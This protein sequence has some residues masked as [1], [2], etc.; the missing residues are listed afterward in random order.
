MNRGGEEG[1]YAWS[2]KGLLSVVKAVWMYCFHHLLLHL[3]FLITSYMYSSQFA[4]CVIFFSPEMML[5]HCDYQEWCP[6]IYP[7]KRVMIFVCCFCFESMSNLF[8]CLVSF[9]LDWTIPFCSVENLFFPK[10]S[11]NAAYLKRTCMLL[12][13]FFRSFL[14]RAFVS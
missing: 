7:Y 3:S 2:R 6:F 12:L 14:V 10:G 8:I 11:K 4:S 1:G 13:F 5:C 9:L